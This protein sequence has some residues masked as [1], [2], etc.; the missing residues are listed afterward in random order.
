MSINYTIKA[1][2]I[3]AYNND[4]GSGMFDINDNNN[5]NNIS[6]EVELPVSVVIV[7]SIFIVVFLMIF[8]S[9]NKFKNTREMIIRTLKFRNNS[10]RIASV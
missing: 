8:F 2:N 5:S 9:S 10:Q 6:N 4:L 3:S 1:T 7:L